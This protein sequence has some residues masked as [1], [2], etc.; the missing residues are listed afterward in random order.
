MRRPLDAIS[1]DNY[2]SNELIPSSDIYRS[3]ISVEQSRI[4]AEGVAVIVLEEVMF[5]TG[6]KVVGTVGSIAGGSGGR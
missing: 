4:V 5:G 1:P 6:L 2:P 3:A